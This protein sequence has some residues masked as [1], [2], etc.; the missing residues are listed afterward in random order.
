MSFLSLFFSTEK[1]GGNSYFIPMPDK[2][3]TNCRFEWHRPWRNKAAQI[4]LGVVF[5]VERGGEPKAGLGYIGTNEGYKEPGA[6]N[7]PPKLSAKKVKEFQDRVAKELYL[8]N[9]PRSE[10]SN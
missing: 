2:S 10:R 1:N 4:R 7:Y 9:K 5:D 8:A 6:S 3:T